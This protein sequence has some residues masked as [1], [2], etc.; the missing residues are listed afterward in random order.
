[1]PTK[2]DART[3]ELLGEIKSRSGEQAAVKAAGAGAP[4]SGPGGLFSRL[5]ETFSGR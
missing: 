5:R 3:R 4:S 1:M 2:L